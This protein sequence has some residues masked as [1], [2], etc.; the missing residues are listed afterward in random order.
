MQ[1]SSMGH[2]QHL[3]A[4]LQAC[5][6]STRKLFVDRQRGTHRGGQGCRHEQR[7][8]AEPED[9]VGHDET[10][11][12]RMPVRECSGRHVALSQDCDHDERRM[13]RICRRSWS[14][15]RDVRF[16]ASCLQAAGA[17]VS[18]LMQGPRPSAR[19][20][21]PSRGSCIA[22]QAVRSKGA[23][24]CTRGGGVWPQWW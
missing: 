24:Y 7:G 9:A 23:G 20:V 2:H 22:M 21:V 4:V 11:C 5:I 3:D 17:C 19:H 13:R 12:S 6:S 1:R 8:Q 10:P 16:L 18:L 14:S 15:S